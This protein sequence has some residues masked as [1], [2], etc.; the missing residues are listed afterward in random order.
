MFSSC[1][2]VVD[3]LVCKGFVM[4]YRLKVVDIGEFFSVGDKISISSCM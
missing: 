4:F 3:I 1:I 2:I